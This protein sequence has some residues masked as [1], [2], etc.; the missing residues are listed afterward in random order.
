M[1]LSRQAASK[2]LEAL[3]EVQP[4]SAERSGLETGFSL[5]L[6]RLEAVNTFL[7]HVGTKQGRALERPKAHAA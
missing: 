4:A 1:N 7:V 3:S 5:E 6:F 2:H